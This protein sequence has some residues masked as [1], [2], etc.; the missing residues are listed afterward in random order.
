[1][2]SSKSLKAQFRKPVLLLSP[3]LPK[4]RHRAIMSRNSTVARETYTH[5]FSSF[6]L[7]AH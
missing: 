6:E 5:R 2:F 4:P 7:F 1:M 3:V